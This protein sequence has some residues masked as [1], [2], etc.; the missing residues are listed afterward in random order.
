[1]SLEQIARQFP[2]HLGLQ[3]QAMLREYL[4]CVILEILYESAFAEKFC[5]LDGTSRQQ[6]APHLH[7]GPAPTSPAAAP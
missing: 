6:P 4:Q 2:A 5:F 7:S 3:K 1:M